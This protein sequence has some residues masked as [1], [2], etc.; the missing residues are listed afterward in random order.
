MVKNKSTNLKKIKSKSKFKIKEIDK[1]IINGALVFG[2]L[3]LLISCS[4][5]ICMVN[6]NIKLN[7]V[8]KNNEAEFFLESVSPHYLFLGDSITE[9]YDLKKHFKNYSVVNSGKGGNLTDDILNSLQDRVYK[10]NPSTV[11]LMI[12]TND[13]NQNKSA[14][15]IYNN[16]E[17][18]VEEIQFNLPM[19][20][21]MVLSIL[22][23]D[24]AW[25]LND[26]NDKR[27][28]INNML[29]EKY[30]DNRVQYIDLYSLLKETDSNKI[31]RDYTTDGL[32]LNDEG[33]ELISKKIKEYMIHNN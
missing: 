1:K 8:L 19:T 23:S 12:G 21:V 7:K 27:I 18:I 2:V 24:E 6:M 26:D 16:I 29:R 13:V 30:R 15:Y 17:K 20:R 25:A 33:Y 5:F 31:N 28:K 32:H 22:P 4:S 14:K 10:Y 3:L 9:Q 11:F